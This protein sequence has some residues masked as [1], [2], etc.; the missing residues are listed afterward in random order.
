MS[1]L[2][3]PPC[4]LVWLR[5][6]LRLHDHAALAAALEQSEPVQLVFIFDTD[7]LK[8]F[9]QKHDRRLSFLMVT[10]QHLHRQLTERGG[11]LIILHGKAAEVMP[12]AAEVLNARQVFA[13]GDHEPETRARDD[14]IAELL[15]EQ[16]SV[17]V[18]RN[19]TFILFPDG[20]RLLNKTG[21]PYKVF[22][23]F[24]R[25][26]RGILPVGAFNETQIPDAGRYA[27][28][29]ASVQSL[30]RAELTVLDPELATS[31]LLALIGYAKA[32]FEPWHPQKA[33]THLR[34]FMLEKITT[35]KTSRDL[36]GSPGTSKLSPYLRFG[37]LSVRQVA[38][39]A[40]EQDSLE[41]TWMNE[42]I[43]REFYAMILY[44]FPHTVK[45]EF[46][47]KYR[48]LD[49]Q[50]DEETLK[51][52]Q[53]GQTGYPVVDAAMRQLLQ[54]G[55][56]HNRARMIVASFLCKHLRI[57]WRLGEEHFAQYLMDYEL[58]SNVGGWQWA[59]SVGTDAQPY[60]RV[61]NPV[62]QSQK[63]DPAGEYIR[64]YV[65]E[66]ARLSDKD[67]HLPPS[68][69]RPTGY[70]APIVEHAVARQAALAMFKRLA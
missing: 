21:G 55:W 1:P 20:Q 17:L 30:R 37:L 46:V 6:D 58:S 12:R 62:A 57:D 44:H 22:T 38:R 52:W 41:G 47:E 51:R 13:A 11:G 7:I 64:R 33:E 9:Q 65:P 54:T 61:F 40:V 34:Q 32:L 59:A 15:A 28:Y 66:L 27:D 2:V 18:L 39:L 43:W 56:M 68:G 14:M 8:R 48:D 24:A 69:K 50:R 29:T 23:P 67:I 63:F 26:W 19:D 16:G 45:L 4:S 53:Q 3:K 25:N 10:L 42:I 36:M 70:P 49:W 31:E 35:Y 60:F 5:R